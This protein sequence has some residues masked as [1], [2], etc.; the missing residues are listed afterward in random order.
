[1]KEMRMKLT[2]DQLQSVL[3]TY[4]KG[5][6]SHGAHKAKDG[7]Y[8]A[9]ECISLARHNGRDNFTDDPIQLGMP[10]IRPLNDGPWSSD[11]ARTKTLLPLLAALSDWA[12][13]SKKRQQVW[14]EYVCIGTVKHLLSVMPCLTES[15]RHL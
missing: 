14:S 6:L 3:D 9:L 8:C 10:D 5:V 2:V 11:S 15:A 12:L 13:W 4:D 7:A 1:M